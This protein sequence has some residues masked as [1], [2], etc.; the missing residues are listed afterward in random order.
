MRF[1]F[2]DTCFYIYAHRIRKIKKNN[3]FVILFIKSDPVTKINK[4]KTDIYQNPM[5]RTSESA[6]ASD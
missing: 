1:Y 3:V 2:S 6:T 4:L 5:S